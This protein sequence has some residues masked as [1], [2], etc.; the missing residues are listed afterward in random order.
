MTGAI[1]KIGGKSTGKGRKRE[2]TKRQSKSLRTLWRR[3]GGSTKTVP[4]LSRETN[5]H[6]SKSDRD[7]V[8]GIEGLLKWKMSGT[9]RGD[10]LTSGEPPLVTTENKSSPPG[11]REVPVLKGQSVHQNTENP[12]RKLREEKKSNIIRTQPMEQVKGTSALQSWG[13]GEEI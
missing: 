8:K 12:H 7:T 9:P 3:R 11:G 1:R 4:S 2:H 5:G 6:I 10:G 13:Q